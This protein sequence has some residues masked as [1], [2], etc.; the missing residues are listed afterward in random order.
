MKRRVPIT[1]VHAL[2]AAH[3]EVGGNSQAGPYEGGHLG[4][5]FFRIAGAAGYTCLLLVTLALTSA[6]PAGAQPVCVSQF[7]KWSEPI[8][9]CYVNNPAGTPC[10]VNWAG[11]DSGPAISKDELELYF[12]RELNGDGDPDPGDL[13]VSTREHKKDPW[14]S[15]QNLGLNINTVPTLFTNDGLPING[16]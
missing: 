12:V 4:K 13:W 14:G 1:V 2:S 5:Q 3:G 11:T 16:R 10:K 6:P 8:N 7:S 15:P 9:L